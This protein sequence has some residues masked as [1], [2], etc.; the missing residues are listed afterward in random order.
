MLGRRRG[1]IGSF[2]AIEGIASLQLFDQE[3]RTSDTA[4][5]R[6]PK[7]MILR[8][9]ET[10]W[11]GYLADAHQGIVEYLLRSTVNAYSN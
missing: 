6:T 7:A 10:G 5:A 1:I 11:D 2:Y 9:L 8:S 3:V 4:D